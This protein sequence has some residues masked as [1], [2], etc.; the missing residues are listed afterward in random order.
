[1]AIRYE[2]DTHYTGH[3]AYARTCLVRCR[4]EGADY[5][6]KRPLN[7]QLHAA[8]AT[9][10]PAS[11]LAHIHQ[12]VHAK[13]KKNWDKSNHPHSPTIKP[14]PTCPPNSH[15]LPCI[16]MQPCGTAHPSCSKSL[17]AKSC[18]SNGCAGRTQ[19][20]FQTVSKAWT[21]HRTW[22]L[23]QDVGGYVPLSQRAQRMCLKSN[24]SDLNQLRQQACQLYLQV[25]KRRSLDCPGTHALASER[26]RGSEK[27]K[28]QLRT[29][30]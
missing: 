25:F 4:K 22:Q 12:L 1:M 11:V 6:E 2:I 26:L 18:Q 29:R 23:H 17:P 30:M 27:H 24:G 14:Q 5:G 8:H 21:T 28:L 20:V 7:L 3:S 9:Y 13:C 10:R 19:V 16:H 15:G